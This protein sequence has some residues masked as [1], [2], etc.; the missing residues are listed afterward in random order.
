MT[1]ENSEPF[2]GFEDFLLLNLFTILLPASCLPKGDNW[3]PQSCPVSLGDSTFTSWLTQNPHK[4]NQNQHPLSQS[5]L[6]LFSLLW[7][8]GDRWCKAFRHLAGPQVL[9]LLLEQPTHSSLHLTCNSFGLF[10]PSFYPKAVDSDSD[11]F[12]YK[13]RFCPKGVFCFSRLRREKWFWISTLKLKGE[14][15]GQRENKRERIWYQERGQHI[16]CMF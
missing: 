5:I 16:K 2:W 6:W 9:P 7:S 13:G 15:T 8:S 11:N 1:N 10:G 12:L 4:I 14:E 3:L